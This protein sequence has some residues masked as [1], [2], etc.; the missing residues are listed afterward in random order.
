MAIESDFLP[1]LNNWMLL[2]VVTAFGYYWVK[3]NCIDRTLKD[4]SAQEAEQTG[5]SHGY[6][7]KKAQ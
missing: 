6:A 1:F 2:F 3:I 7:V 5:E 4:L